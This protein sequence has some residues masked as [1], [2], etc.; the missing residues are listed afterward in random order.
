LIHSIWHRQFKSMH[1]CRGNHRQRT[2]QLA[3]PQPSS[4]AVHLLTSPTD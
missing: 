3:N 2:R 4:E 1:A